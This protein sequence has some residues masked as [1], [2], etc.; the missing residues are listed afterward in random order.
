MG[1]FFIVRLMMFL[2]PLGDGDVELLLVV[3]GMGA[4]V[5]FG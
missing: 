4:V 2:Y 1:L 3:S 5:I